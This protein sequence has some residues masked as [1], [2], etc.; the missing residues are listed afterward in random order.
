ME[1]VRSR[2]GG[3]DDEIY[4]NY[5]ILVETDCIIKITFVLPPAVL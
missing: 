3:N 5:F 2:K 1:E 4:R